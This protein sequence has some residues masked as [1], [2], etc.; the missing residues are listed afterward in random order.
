EG[1]LAG[2]WTVAMAQGTVAG[3]NAAGESRVYE[4]GL[5]FY[6]IKALGMEILIYGELSGA[7]RFSLVNRNRPAFGKLFFREDRLSALELIGAELPFF[8]MQ[9]AVEQ[10]LPR[11]EAIALLRQ[12]LA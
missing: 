2:L 8:Q 5:P 10:Q 9:K 1:Q 3:A 6:S 11:K 7:E 4:P 12:L